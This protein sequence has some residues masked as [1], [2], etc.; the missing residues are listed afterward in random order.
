MRPDRLLVTLCL[1]CGLQIFS[2]GAFP[3][4]LPEIGRGAALAD[5]QLGAVAGAFGFARMLIDVPAGLLMTHHVRRALVGGPVF[6]LIGIVCVVL[7]GGSFAWLLLGRVLMGAGHTLGQLSMLTTLLRIRAERRLASALAAF[8][9]SAMLGMLGG[10]GLVGA[11][12][13]TLPWQTA[14]VIACSPLLGVGVTLHQLLALLPDDGRGRPW[15]A[16]SA[17]TVAAAATNGP[18]AHRATTVLAFAAGGAIA[19]AYATLEQFLIP[20]R[21]SRE[22]GLDRSGIARLLMVAQVCDTIA[23]LPLGALAD[24]RGI[25][26]VLGVV[27]LT[28]A[29]AVAMIGLGPLPLVVAG[30]VV[31]GLSMAGWMLPVGLLRAA[32][33]AAQVAWRTAVFRVFVDGGMFLGPFAS[34]LLGAAHA[35]VL[36]AALAAA[37]L[38]VGIALLA[39]SAR[40]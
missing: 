10:V 11:L 30:C 7:G 3:A 20:V 13:S 15:F 16:R 2:L 22:F 32:T 36:P 28:F 6:V 8:E 39:R 9:F 5:W 1:T 31:F 23:L 40:R 38:V 17:A 4:L 35:R 34:G 19:F 21:G 33:P 37:L 24:R 25:R 27:L 18:P 12:P 14:F 26:R 29:A